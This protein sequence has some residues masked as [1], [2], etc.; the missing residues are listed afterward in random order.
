MSRR[1]VSFVPGGIYHIYTRGA[2][3]HPIF[4]EEENYL[5]LLQ[6][7]KKYVKKFDVGVLAYCLMPNHYHLLLR[8]DGAHSVGLVVQRTFNSYTKAVNRRYNRSGTLFEGK[9]KAIEVDKPD[10]LIHLCRYI[11]A[12]P[13]K[14]S[15]VD[16]PEAWPYSNYREWMGL[17]NGELW[18]PSLMYEYV[19][20]ADAYRSLV[21]E[22]I[23]DHQSLPEGTR[24]FLV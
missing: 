2:G 10:Y 5:F 20:N 16:R 13:V 22:Y 24:R 11:H 14:A 6:R 3:R 18:D 9:Y 15:L 21:E 7:L 23:R 1:N 4:F 19:P 12:N 8:Q 17:R